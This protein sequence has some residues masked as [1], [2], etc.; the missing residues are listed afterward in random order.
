MT[1]TKDTRMTFDAMQAERDKLAARVSE[2]ESTMGVVANNDRDTVTRCRTLTRDNDQLR[3][4][5]RMI[6]K[7]PQGHTDKDAGKDCAAMCRIARKALGE[8]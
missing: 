8:E 6:Y 4:A 3:A 5:L 7:Q 2:L 1:A